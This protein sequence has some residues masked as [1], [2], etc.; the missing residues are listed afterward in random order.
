[1]SVYEDFTSMMEL[2]GWD[3]RP[4]LM[5][6]SDD[7]AN[8]LYSMIDVK[9]QNENGISDVFQDI[10]ASPVSDG[11]PFSQD[12]ME[13]T[14]L[15]QM[16]EELTGMAMD[17]SVQASVPSDTENVN[18]VLHNMD[19][20]D[21]PVFTDLGLDGFELLE[22]L[23]VKA[24]ELNTGFQGSSISS[25]SE[26]A[27]TQVLPVISLDDSGISSLDSSLCE[28]N[29]STVDLNDVEDVMHSPLSASD[30]DSLLS[31]P[32]TSPSSTFC[33]SELFKLMT[34]P[35]PADLSLSKS[36]SVKSTA[37]TQSAIRKSKVKSVSKDGLEIE[38]LNKKEKK[39]LQNKNAAIRYRQKKKIES[40]E[41]KKEEDELELK[42]KTLSDKVEELQREIIYMKN[43]MSE[44]YKARDGGV[45]KI[46]KVSI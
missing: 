36:T 19:E 40:D 7:Q 9:P 13:Q 39:K 5:T 4:G 28:G 8:N 24:A 16:L 14:S 3:S 31:S 2:E 35:T 34:Q 44:V 25:L 11:D 1:M 45:V 27:K 10:L 18:P 20:V 26:A 38:F 41:I 42:N 22:Q 46:T 23:V 17:S 32:P 12:W 29:A 33:H 21:V 30:V 15:T 6:Q 37:P 43:L